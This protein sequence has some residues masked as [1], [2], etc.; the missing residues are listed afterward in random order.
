[1]IDLDYDNLWNGNGGDLVR[2]DGVRYATLGA[3]AA[4]TGHEAHGL[5]VEPGFADPANG[6]YALAST[7]DLIDAGV[8]IPGI[9]DDYAGMSPDV[10]AFEHQPS[11]T[12]HGMPGDGT[13]HLNWEVGT[14]LPVT[15]TWQIT[16]SPP[17]GVPPSPVTGLA[18]IRFS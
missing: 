4:A 18:A 13:I 14:S 11:L 16:Y 1:M 6:D 5:S 17:V 2:W 3:F 9:N 8:T 12:L 7:S 15:S 10:G